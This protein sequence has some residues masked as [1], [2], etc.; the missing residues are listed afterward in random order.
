M[1]SLKSKNIYD[2]IVRSI[3]SILESTRLF[4]AYGFCY[5]GFLLTFYPFFTILISEGL[6]NS[7]WAFAFLVPF[8]FAMAAGYLYNSICDADKD[9]AEKN[10]ITRGELPRKSAVYLLLF[11]IVFSLLL[12][13]FV[14]KNPFTLIS[15]VIYSLLWLTYSG[16][17]IRFKES[18]FAPFI[19]SYVLWVGGSLTLMVE[20]GFLNFTTSCLLTGLFNLYVAAEIS[21]ELDDY[22]SDLKFNCN[23][24]AVKIGR[25]KATVAAR[26]FTLVGY[27]LFLVCVYLSPWTRSFLLVFILLPILCI[28]WFKFIHFHFYPHRPLSR[29][30]SPLDLIWRAFWPLE[31]MIVIYGTMLL[32]SNIS[33]TIVLLSILLYFTKYGT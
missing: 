6:I 8:V 30:C 11:L 16:L 27:S 7:P 29:A 2:N 25:Q 13:L 15:F 12:S 21:H 22:E 28:I 33:I 3:R 23:T 14:F 20:Y 9:P 10:P 1:S 24:F 4:S 26:L 19:A 5:A 18:Y 32:S 17:N 31:F